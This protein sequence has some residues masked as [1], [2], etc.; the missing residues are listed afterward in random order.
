MTNLTAEFPGLRHDIGVLE[1]KSLE[2]RELR[3]PSNSTNTLVAQK[4]SALVV[5]KVLELLPLARRLPIM[6]KWSDN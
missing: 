2:H 5:V 3:W 4:P 1:I 6:L